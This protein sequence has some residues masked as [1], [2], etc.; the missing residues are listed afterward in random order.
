VFIPHFLGA[1]TDLNR[2]A[3]FFIKRYEGWFIDHN[4][5]AAYTDEGVGCAEVYA[6][7]QR[8]YAKQKIERTL[9]LEDSSRKR[10]AGG[11]ITRALPNTKLSERRANYTIMI[12]NA[13]EAPLCCH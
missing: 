2:A 3:C 10:E 8:K 6:D 4:T 13:H 11:I 12:N 9:H 1:R 7:V 5:L